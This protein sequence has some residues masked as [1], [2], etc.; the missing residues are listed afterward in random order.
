ML[1]G[2]TSVLS[3]THLGLLGPGWC[4]AIEDGE[5]ALVPLH[6]L[7]DGHVARHHLHLV[8]VLGLA[9]GVL[10]LLG[11]DEVELEEEHPPLSALS[12]QLLWVPDMEGVL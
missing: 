1:T 4:P 8:L 7:R 9:V 10:H 11:E 12:Y 3:D 6:V 2:L 5:L